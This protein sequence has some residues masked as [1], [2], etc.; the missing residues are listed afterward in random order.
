MP[1]ALF[2]AIFATIA[3]IVWAVLV[4]TIRRPLIHLFVRLFATR[5]S[6]L[7]WA[8]FIQYTSLIIGNVWILA[9]AG[10]GPVHIL[11]AMTAC[12]VLYVLAVPP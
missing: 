4:S 7:Y 2:T 12:C 5:E 1:S 3:S 9:L 11:L 8:D 6:A 10:L